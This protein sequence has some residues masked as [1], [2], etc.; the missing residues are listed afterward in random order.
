VRPMYFTGVSL[1]TSAVDKVASY[2]MFSARHSPFI[3]HWFFTIQLQ[4]RL[5]GFVVGLKIF[6]LWLSI[7][8]FMFFVQ[9]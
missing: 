9:L 2:M 1:I 6:L 5:V 7:N 8:A 4:V 3:G